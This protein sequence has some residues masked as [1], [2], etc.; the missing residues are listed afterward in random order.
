MKAMI[1]VYMPVVIMK[2]KNVSVML[3]IQL[4][5]LCFLINM[6]ILIR[7]SVWSF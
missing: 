3:L 7:Y 5:V 2:T 1:I 6:N 4:Q